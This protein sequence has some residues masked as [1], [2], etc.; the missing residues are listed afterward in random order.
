MTI[1]KPNSFKFLSRASLFIC[2]LMLLSACSLF[3]M[4]EQAEAAANTGI[5][6]GKVELKSEQKGDTVIVLIKMTD[7]KHYI[8]KD[9]VLVDHDGTYLLHVVSGT[10]FLGAFVDLNKDGA[11]SKGEHARFYGDF[12][13]VTVNKGLTVNANISIT[14]ILKRDIPSDV[15]VLEQKSLSIKNIGRIASLDE[16][17]FSPEAGSL[18]LWKPVDFLKKYG[19]G[20]FL[21]GQYE[22]NK[23]P[24]IF[25]HGANGAS[26]DWGTI[27]DSVDRSKFQPWVFNYPSGLRLGLI[28]EY[29]N[30]A[31][32]ELQKEHK[33]KTVYVIAHSMGGLVMRSFIKKYTENH[34]AEAKNIRF[35]MSIN[36]PMMGM[37]SAVSGVEHSPIVVPSWRDIAAGSDFI[38]G[39][40]TWVWPKY[41]PYY[42][43]F[44]YKSGDGDDGVVDLESQIPLELQIEAR[45]VYGFNSTHAGVLRDKVFINQFNKMLKNS[46]H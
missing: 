19:A 5:I 6:S 38:K 11:Y 4:K 46:L 14:G 27:V 39:I 23:I 28:S 16:A 21:L 26:G 37:K 10:Y 31:V 25:I 8:I 9:Q 3:E 30:R 7:N 42:L 29:L 43:M 13:P 45:R 18:G 44:S 22:K 15:E 1:Q 2:L 34:P 17:M 20:L 41:I 40:H 12:K 36:S 24:V 33:L 32:Y 35:A